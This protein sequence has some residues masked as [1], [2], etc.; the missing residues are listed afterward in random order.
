MY[1]QI[2]NLLEIK[3]KAKYSEIIF[4]SYLIKYFMSYTNII[5]DINQIR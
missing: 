5:Q 1:A 4:Y 3:N 2:T